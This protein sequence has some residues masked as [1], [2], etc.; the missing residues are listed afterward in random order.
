[1]SD[2]GGSQSVCV[3]CKDYGKLFLN[4][5]PRQRTDAKGNIV[6]LHKQ[7]DY[8]YDLALQRASSP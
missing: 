2:A 4:D 8:W 6:F 7:C 5:V 1:M 3:Q